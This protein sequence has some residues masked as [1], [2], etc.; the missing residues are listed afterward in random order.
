EL[1]GADLRS[2]RSRA[3][4][5][6]NELGVSTTL[7]VTVKKG[8]NDGEL[9]RIV[10]YAL[11]QPCVR[12]V[13]FQPVQAAG[14]LMDF[15]QAKDRLTLTEVRRRILEQTA[16]FRPE[17]IIPV[18][19]HPDSLAMAYAIKLDGCT[20]P[21]TGMID[22]QILI[23]AGRNTIVF[24]ADEKLHQQLFK[25]FSTNHSPQ[26][27]AASLRDLLCCLPRVALPQGIG[28][29]NLFRVII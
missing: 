7:V 12:G 6:L 17:D 10:D 20:T 14:R 19:C 4:E 9:G 3:L 29:E 16:L 27:S 24:E 8:A 21:L 11:K 1:R 28:Y 25:V 18:P 22:P 5:R 26:S 23:N 13:V 2:I 15:D